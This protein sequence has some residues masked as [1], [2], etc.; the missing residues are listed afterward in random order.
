MLPAIAVLHGRHSAVRDSG[1]VLALIAGT[2]AVVVGL[3]ASVALDLR[4]AAL[5]VL[6]VWWWTIG[7]MW[8]TTSVLPA[9]FGLVT[10]TLGVLAFVGAGALLVASDALVPGLAAGQSWTAVHAAIGAWLV[11]LA[12][13]LYRVRVGGP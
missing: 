13:V 11:A 9:I 7:K 3:A 1:A 2:A 6:G 8:A 10:A 4:P 12:A 5:V